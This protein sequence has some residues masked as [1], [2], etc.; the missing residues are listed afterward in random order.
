[1]YEYKKQDVFNLAS[2]IG[3]EVKQKGDELFFKYCPNC[4]ARIQ[5]I[6]VIN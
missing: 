1:M 4:S 3:A 5:Y 6:D 2:F